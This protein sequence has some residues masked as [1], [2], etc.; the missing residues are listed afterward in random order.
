MEN[1]NAEGLQVFA[2]YSE[3]T[4]CYTVVSVKGDNTDRAMR[5]VLGEMSPPGYPPVRW[6]ASLL[7][8]SKWPAEVL[9][10]I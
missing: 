4:A 8:H 7:R 6:P 1:F 2:T 9:T 10:A 3:E 5:S